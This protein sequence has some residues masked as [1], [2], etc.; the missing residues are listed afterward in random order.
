MD[1][2][3]ILYFSALKIVAVITVMEKIFLISS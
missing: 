3:F 1:K 2:T